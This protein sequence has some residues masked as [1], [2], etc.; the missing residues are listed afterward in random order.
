MFLLQGIERKTFFGQFLITLA[1]DGDVGRIVGLEDVTS[2]L[3]MNVVE[4]HTFRMVDYDTF[5]HV[6]YFKIADVDIANWHLWQTVEIGCTASSA[7]DDMLD[8]DIAE[9][10]CG[11]VNLEYRHTLLLLLVAIG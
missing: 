3:N 4:C 6:V 9:A 5:F 1:V 8:V 10:W 11:F 7:T 2:G